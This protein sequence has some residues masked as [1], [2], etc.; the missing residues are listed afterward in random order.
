MALEPRCKA[1]CA[2]QT[3][4]LTAIFLM[5]ALLM[6]AVL[7]DIGRISVERH[8]LANA[9]GAAAKAGLV[10]VGDQM[11]TQALAQ[12]TLAAQSPCVPDAGYGTPGATCTATPSPANIP[13]WLTNE[14]RQA[15]VAAPMRTQVAVRVQQNAARNQVAPGDPGVASFE[16]IYPYAYTPAAHNLSIL[17]RI[18]RE[19]KI[20]LFGFWEGSETLGI[21]AE[22]KQSILQK[23][24]P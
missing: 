14:D 6:L 3:T 5:G 10:T 9:A 8:E 20:L 13:A 22:S 11:M 7:V 16:V 24:E 17:V 1:R 4:V 19:V 21:E 15:L 23:W 2:G 18:R 12:Q